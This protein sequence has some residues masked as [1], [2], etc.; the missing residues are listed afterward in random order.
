MG[1]SLDA[2]IVVPGIMDPHKLPQ[3]SELLPDFAK[4]FPS[5]DELINLARENRLE[6]KIA[7]QAIKTN[8]A[9]LR[10]AY[11]NILPS[12]RFVVG[13]ALELNPPAPGPIQRVPLFQA[14][15]DAPVFNFQQGDIAKFKATEK[16]L[17]LDLRGQENLIAG[18]VEFAY[19]NLLAA[20][21]R[22]R[23][24]QEEALVEA[25]AVA[26]IAKHGYELGQT[27]LNTLLD[28]QRTNIQTK[29]QYLDSILTYQLA[30]NDL[31]QGIGIPLE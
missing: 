11:G 13:Q 26:S 17:K 28:A 5:R 27:D 31:E 14:Y 10:N 9:N 2:P 20:R 3:A 21:Q 8:S 1:K 4:P 15:V 24:F 19:K 6:L 22:I 16:Q 25:D 12:P 18:Q 7:K 30:I 23:S 29:T